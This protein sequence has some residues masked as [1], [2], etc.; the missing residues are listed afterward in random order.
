MMKFLFFLLLTVVS[1]FVPAARPAFSATRLFMSDSEETKSGT[2]KWFNTIKGFGFI[3][4]DDGSDDIFVH[5]TAIKAEGFRSLADGE[6]VEF[7]V[8]EDDNGRRKA[9]KV[10]GPEGSNVQ[11]APFRPQNDYDGY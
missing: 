8:E 1:A 6:V 2:V 3:V 11:G 10:T 5:Q 7:L 4:P 9:S